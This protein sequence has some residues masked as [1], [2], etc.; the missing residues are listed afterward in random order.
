MELMLGVAKFDGAR[1]AS[2][3]LDA[4]Q[5]LHPEAEW[6]G[7]VAIVSRGKFGRISAY[8][9]FAEDAFGGAEGRSPLTGLGVGGAT[10][11]LAGALAG[12]AGMVLAGSVGVAMGGLLGAVHEAEK[13][14]LYDL[15]RERL[16][17]DSSSLLLLADREHVETMLQAFAPAAVEVLRRQ[18]PADACG[19]LEAAFSA[20]VLGPAADAAPPPH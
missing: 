20:L 10:G 14:P 8:G 17:K 12:P 2:Q 19:R 11:M 13:Q 4:Y 6:V 9:S 3:V 5:T 18:V 7:D 15:V 16:G 1:R